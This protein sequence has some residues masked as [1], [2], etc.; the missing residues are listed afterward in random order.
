MKLGIISDIHAN[1][2]GLEAVL[3]CLESC[4]YILCAGDISGYSPLINET[5]EIFK[6]SNIF[7]IMGNHDYFLLHGCPLSKND[8]VQTSVML[9]QKLIDPEYLRIIKDLH[10]MKVIDLDDI[11]IKIVHGSPMNIL[12]GYVYPDTPLD[13][14]KFRMDEEDVLILGHTHY[15]MIKQ[16]KNFKII[17]PGSCGQPRDGTFKAGYA[18]LDTLTLQI[19]LGKVSFDTTTLVRQLL[20]ANWPVDL[21]KHLHKS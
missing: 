2:Y 16:F 5:I 12:E 8:I 14:K 20:S 19:E 17:N 18:I 15:Q 21:L 11:K 7:S 1:P 6:T 3:S 4:D 9:T 13:P 10:M